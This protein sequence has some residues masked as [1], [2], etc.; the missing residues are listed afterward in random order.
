MAGMP[1]LGL[2]AASSSISVKGGLS[3]AIPLSPKQQQ[4]F[5]S[6]RALYSDRPPPMTEKPRWWWRTISCLPYLTPLCLTWAFSEPAFHLHPFLENVEHLALPFLQATLWKMPGWLEI[7]Y[8]TFLQLGVVR[9]K[10]WP[11]FFRFHIL[12]ATLLQMALHIVVC[13][14]QT[15]PLAMFWSRIGMHIWVGLAFIYMF[16]IMECMRC[17]LGGMY[18][19]IPFFCDAAYMQVPF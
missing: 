11:H 4:S 5:V 15:M 19:D 14:C 8:L 16:L 7:A 3:C 9:R 1:H 13:V 17:A 2:A 12:M 18:A 6:P 10:E